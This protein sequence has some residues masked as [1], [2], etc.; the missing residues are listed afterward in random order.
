[1]SAPQ[2]KLI[3]DGKELSPR[4]AS[5]LPNSASY[6]AIIKRISARPELSDSEIVFLPMQTKSQAGR[7]GARNTSFN[8]GSGRW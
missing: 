5:E 7:K 3:I 1:M 8:S 6:Q 2:H 4:Q